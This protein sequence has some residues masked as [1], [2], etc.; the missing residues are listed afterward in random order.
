MPST[1]SE[2]PANDTKPS[3][4]LDRE[5]RIAIAFCLLSGGLNGFFAFWGFPSMV[6][7]LNAFV[8]GIALNFIWSVVIIARQ[9]R[10]WLKLLEQ[11]SE[12]TNRLLKLFDI[13]TGSPVTIT[14]ETNPL[15]KPR[16][17]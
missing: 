7:L 8:A 2:T 10:A 4:L 11:S 6:S 9:R 5:D 3:P 13:P 12:N 1:V 15:E 16:M 14:V 17:H